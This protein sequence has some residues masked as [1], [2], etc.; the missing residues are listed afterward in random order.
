M[1]DY[2]SNEAICF[3][4][5]SLEVGYRNGFYGA[6]Q[7][8][9]Q[10]KL[11]TRYLCLPVMR[12]NLIEIPVCVPDDLQLHDG[13]GLGKEGMSQV[14]GRVLDN[15]YERGELFTLMFHPEL[16][17]FCE[18]PFESLLVKARQF[19]LPVWIARLRD[20]SEWW[21]EK[22]KFGVDIKLNNTG[23]ELTF[24][25]SPRA[26]IL[27][28]G[29]DSAESGL[30]WDGTY[31]KLQSNT[32]EVPAIPRPFIGITNGISESVI[33][34]LRE[35]GYILDTGETARSCG[36]ILDTEILTTLPNNVELVNYI[37]ASRTPLVRYWRWPNGAK[38]AM[39][40]TGDL[41]ALS[42]MDYVSRLF[43][44]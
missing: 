33:S 3:E 34:F 14:W 6:L 18:L 35:Q 7:R 41:D 40:I 32:I 19:S 27:A 8:F 43:I 25:C 2:S 24:E 37:E 15:I 9:Y 12:P 44:S 22:S 17:T 4:A 20:I 26:T 29:L 39:S 13:M 16:A 36:L 23:M 5:E 1:F 28:R 21:C 42:L 11:F 31:Y 30:M 38:S 10:S